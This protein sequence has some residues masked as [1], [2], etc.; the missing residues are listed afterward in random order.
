MSSVAVFEEA[1]KWCKQQANAD[2]VKED[3]DE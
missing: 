3:T 1:A 2:Q